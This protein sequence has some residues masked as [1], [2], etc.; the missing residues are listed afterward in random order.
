MNSTKEIQDQNRQATESTHHLNGFEKGQANFK[1]LID[2][3][4]DYSILMV[5]R[6]GFIQS[7]N[8]GAELTHGYKAQEIIG[9]HFSKFYTQ[10][11]IDRKHP[12]EELKIALA[13]GRFEEEGWRVRKDGTRFW[14]N[15]VITPLRDEQGEFIGF[16]KITRDLSERMYAERALRESEE[17]F[18]LMV[19]SVKDYAI[20]MLD[21][22][23]HVI[24]WNLGAE[25]IK[26]WTEKEIVGR[27]FE[28]FY[29]PEDVAQGKTR[30]ELE[31]AQREGRFEDYGWRL[32]KDGTKFW[33]NVVITALR[34]ENGELRGYSKVTRDVTERKLAE[35]TLK[36]AYDDLES[37]SYSVSHDLRA[38]LRSMDGFS[39]V[40]MTTLGDQLDDR[41]K[42]Y[43]ARIRESSQ[44]MAA[45][46][47]GL[48]NLSRLSRAPI[49]RQE[50]DLSELVN[51]IAADL[52]K[53]S[54]GRRVDW[55]IAR[56]IKVHGD[57]SLLRVALD[58]LVNNAWKYTSKTENPRIEFGVKISQGIPLYFVKDNGAGFEMKFVDKLFGSFQ[59]LHG[60]NE[61]PGNGIG[62]AT[63]KRIVSRHGGEIWAEGQ[64]DQGAQ[65]YFS[66]SPWKKEG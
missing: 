11:D 15:V 45:L 4:P 33:A 38:P 34:G 21:P 25:R 36:K 60:A 7:W 18:R 41:S 39:E 57:P 10:F 48:L 55:V 59:R 47:D 27:S 28:T 62:L 14:V 56:D 50:V 9:K 40:L 26:G 63:V 20:I 44:K 66:L 64:V 6:D 29:P 51:Q 1:L 54:P 37:F 61:F 3:I 16:S 5:D 58:N 42:N 22:A 12:Q 19:A 35:D 53:T 23:G 43:L 46:I 2:S 32:R 30:Y 52:V 17:R 13:K 49:I 31:V 8:L 24:S 65:F